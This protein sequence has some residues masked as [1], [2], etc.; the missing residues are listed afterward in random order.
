MG[1]L[2][3]NI[4]SNSSVS[5]LSQPECQIKGING[6]PRPKFHRESQEN[7]SIRVRQKACPNEM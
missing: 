2:L 4:T 1:L 6:W 5:S 7:W 3:Q